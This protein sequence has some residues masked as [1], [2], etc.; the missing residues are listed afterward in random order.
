MI[1]NY[2]LLHTDIIKKLNSLKL[3][4]RSGAKQMGVSRSTINRIYN[5]KPL[6][7]ETYL[8]ITDWLHKDL[9]KY[10][11]RHKRASY[12]Q[13]RLDEASKISDDYIL[14]KWVKNKKN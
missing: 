2:K 13:K 10:I 9:E 4:Q 11:I 8:L 5:A 12:I 14:H 6:L 1:V 7:L 3:S